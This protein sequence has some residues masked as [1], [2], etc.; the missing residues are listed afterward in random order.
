MVQKL[1][2]QQDEAFAVRLA[3]RDKSV[4]ADILCTYGGHLRQVIRNQ[5]HAALDDDDIENI[6]HDAVF[7]GWGG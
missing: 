2:L 6:I 4:V 1:E 5:K 7:A 3:Q